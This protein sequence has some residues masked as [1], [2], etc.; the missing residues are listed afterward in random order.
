MP[1]FLSSLGL[2]GLLFF[3]ALNPAL[4][5]QGPKDEKDSFELAQR[6]FEDASYVNAAQEF[7]RFILNFPTSERL[8]LAIFRLA[9]SHF[10]GESYPEAVQVF[11]DFVDRF[12]KHLQVASAMR[13][14]AQ[15]FVRLG[16]YTKAGAAFQEVHDAF[17]AGEYAAQD[18]LSAGYNYHKGGDLD[19]GGS[20]FRRLIDRYP[21]T[22]LFHEA[23][24][25]LGLV[26]LQADRHTEALDQFQTLSEFQGTTERK[27]D[28]L[29]QIGELALARQDLVE[30]ERVFSQL[31]KNF[32]K[33]TSAERSYLVRA[34]WFSAQEDWQRAAQIYAEAR[35]ALPRN[36]RRQQAVL[37]LSDV[38]RKMGKNAEART[39]YGEFLKVY[40]SSP[41][42]PEAWLGLGCAYADLRDFRSALEAFKR[43]REEFPSSPTAT[44]ALKEMGDLWRDVGTPQKALTA[45]RNYEDR[46][47]D[48]E[49]KAL[50]R[51]R[52]AA[53]QERH[54]GWYDHAVRSYEQLLGASAP[55][56]SQA[57]FGLAATFEKMGHPNFAIREYRNYLAHHPDGDRAA[58]AE[59]RIKILREFAPHGGGTLPEG[60]LELLT[61]LPA[62]SGDAHAQFMIG[63]F[64][65]ERRDYQLASQRLLASLSGDTPPP[66]APEA[67][68]L[69]GKCYQKLASRA[70]L[71]GRRGKA[72]EYLLLALSA[73]RD[74]V[75]NFQESEWG[76]D[77]ALGLIG[78][79]LAD[80]EP[81]TT[82]A[83]RT[84]E[85]YQGF[86]ETYPKS[87]RLDA[88]LLGTAE[89]HFLLGETDASHYG[90]ALKAYRD[91]TERFPQ[92]PHLEQAHYGIGLCLA[93]SGDYIEAEEALRDF[94]FAFPQSSLADHARFQ[95]GRILL[96]RG[97][98]RSAAE[99]FSEL[100]NAPSTLLLGRSSRT[101]LAE[102]Y[103]RSGD[104]EKAIEIYSA[105]L[106]K[107]EDPTLLRRLGRSYQESGQEAKAI[108]AYS[109]YTRTFP[110]AA[111][112]DSVAFVRAELL[113]YLN[114]TSEAIGAFRE[115]SV[116]FAHSP[117]KEEATRTVGNLLFQSGEYGN[118]LSVY[119]QIPPAARTQTVAAHEVLSHFHLAQIK[120]ARKGVKKF[121]KAYKDA[122]QWL[123]FFDIEEG[124]HYLK[125]GNFKKADQVFKA[126]IKRYPGTKAIAEA[127]YYQIR[128]L[129]RA[130]K[131]EEYLEALLSF[132]NRHPKNQ[133]WSSATLELADLYYKDEDFASAT[134]AYQK[135]LG[136]G[137][138]EE[139][140]PLVLGKLAE[141]HSNL[142]LYSTAI[143]Y[144]RQLV[145]EFPHHKNAK[146][147]RIN[148]GD[149]L[150]RNGNFEQA[151]EQLTP[152]LRDLDENEWSSVQYTI[153][154]CYL[155]MGAHESARREFLKLRYKFKGSANWLASALYGLAESYEAQGDYK[156]AI[157]E[158]EEIQ[159]RFGSASDFG[160]HA[161]NRIQDLEKR[162][163]GE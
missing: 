29:L 57:R 76:D 30:A 128:A 5:A 2:A 102:C 25:N 31:R 36:K 140:K 160:V 141:V 74:V 75:S 22:P 89:G 50:A 51:L 73:H 130:G 101:L 126:V 152:Q 53:I 65:Y 91:L 16:Q 92:S 108:E 26:L 131:A 155:K 97:Y 63:R 146:D 15:S 59:T 107:G 104:Y 162:S 64:L 8:P 106:S 60:L 144:A 18:L 9:E 83:V 103:F 99:E 111:D 35:S 142:K 11:S 120:Q 132:V 121:R 119:R 161:Q 28:A 72:D 156:L 42:A 116:K 54:L 55:Y 118:A 66:F 105:L 61:N 135:A 129:H 79:E 78:A 154:Q 85:A 96:D 32:P 47:T 84:L 43:L 17:P 147:A 137:L 39:L 114:R 68:L 70:R 93:R 12:P 44:E 138:A 88:A 46:V 23:V 159:D 62:L 143:D 34:R 86:Q 148:I 151:I 71:E 125:V 33:S 124:K 122:D 133:H 38:F 4:V 69:L 113:S 123:A 158:L 77:A 20:A 27:P 49:M 3:T 24:Y 13:R 45:Y 134:R 80:L 98:H 40:P 58:E 10:Q 112:V 145:Q 95:L 56:A 87:D 109:V 127:R 90:K 117:L 67:G 19:S 150:H 110:A 21:G 100:L 82:R 81:D 41:F 52:I 48:P 94:L 1:Q 37:G 157:Q 153:A 115:F 14:K 7:R 149:M 163:K 139:E 136:N 6:L